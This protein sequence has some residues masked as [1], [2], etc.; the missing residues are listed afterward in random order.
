MDALP[1]SNNKLVRI[2]LAERMDMTPISKDTTLPERHFD[3]VCPPINSALSAKISKVGCRL[4]LTLVLRVIEKHLDP[5]LD[6]H[7]A[8]SRHDG[9]PLV[10]LAPKKHSQDETSHQ[11]IIQQLQDVL[12]R[13]LD[14]YTM[15][16][17]ISFL[18]TPFPRDQEGHIDEQA[19]HTILKEMK[20]SNPPPASETEQKIR[21]A[22][23]EVL[24]IDVDEIS[25]NSDFFDMGGESLS[26]GYLLS[27]LRRDI[28]VRIPV[29]KL[30]TSSKVFELCELVDQIITASSKPS[31]SPAQPMP[32]FT[33][34]HSSTHPLILI[35]HALPIVVL[36]PMKMAFQWTVLM[37]ALSSLAQ[38]W[39]ESNIASRF[40]ALVSAMFIS[41]ASTQIISP[42][43]GIIFKWVVIGAYEEGMYPM[44]GLYHTRWWIVD[45]VLTIC[46]KVSHF[47]RIC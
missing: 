26:A 29:D 35:V 34:T 22:F 18:A 12:R 1:T 24:G 14:G 47:L 21:K 9:T 17:S 46:G 8:V 44:W 43:C 38:V 25:S 6:A 45:K 39:N 10:Y 15:P 20:N 36:Y 16:S 5:K 11:D 28:G 32:E 30:F 40:L 41:R 3:A 42:I 4:D 13:L 23:A 33:K 37:Y 31:N 19:L 27:L 2:K 7:V